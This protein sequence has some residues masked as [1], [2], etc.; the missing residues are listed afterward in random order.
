MPH[1]VGPEDPD[2]LDQNPTADDDG[3]NDGVVAAFFDIDNTIIRG[4][5]AA[6]LAHALYRREFFGIRDLLRLVVHNARYLTFGENKKQIDTVRSHALSIVAGHTVSEI[7]AIGEEVY[8]QVLELRIYPGTQRLL[9]EHIEAGHEVWLVSAT[10]AEIGTLISRRLGGTGALGSVAETVDGVYTG[11][12]VGDMMH[13]KAKAAGVRAL[14]EQRGIDLAASSAYGDSLNDV[15]MME[16]VGNPCAINP[17]ARLRRHAARVGWPVREFRGRRNRA[18]RRG[19]A[20]LSWAGA[21]WAAALVARSIKR[22]V[23]R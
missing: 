21:V 10:P 15:S 12:M 17:D 3:A 11:R 1:D 7:V 9:N 8:D 14:A 5:S 18:A 4:A 6:H 22:T 20:T 16:T 19:A 2:P 23:Q 13:G